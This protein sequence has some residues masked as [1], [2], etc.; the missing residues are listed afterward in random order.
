MW[1][2]EVVLARVRYVDYVRDSQRLNDMSVARMVPVAKIKTTRED[3]IRVTVCVLPIQPKKNQME[4]GI[5]W[6][7]ELDLEASNSSAY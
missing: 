1:F 5:Y 7:Q 2:C 6:Q 4:E 3:L